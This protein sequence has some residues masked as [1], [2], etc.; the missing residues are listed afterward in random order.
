M[1]ANVLM[2]GGDKIVVNTNM[3]VSSIA[4][5]DFDGMLQVTIDGI[6]PN[7]EQL[8]REKLHIDNKYIVSFGMKPNEFSIDYVRNVDVPVIV[9][10]IF[11]TIRYYLDWFGNPSE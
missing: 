7:I 8:V 5:V 11:A 9:E 6:N 4:T 1:S 10:D 3:K 2:Y